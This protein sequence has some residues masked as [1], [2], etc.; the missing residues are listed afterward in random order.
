MTVLR[1]GSATDVG[2]VRAVNEDRSLESETLFAV[3]DGM[4]GHAGGEVAA[5]TA[6]DSLRGGFSKMPS[7]EGLVDAV[8]DANQAVWERGR[9]EPS[10]R[11]MGTTLVAAALVG[12][13]DGDRLAV[14]NVG[15][16][17]AYRLHQGV[18]GQLSTDHS[19]AEALVERGE[20][21]EQEAAVHPHRHIL[22]R[23]LGVDSDVDVDIW[24]LVPQQGDRYLLCS[25]GLSNEVQLE[26]ME[27]VLAGTADPKEAAETL[28]RL[29][30]ESGG[31]D[32]ITALVLDVV[33]G[34]K[35][36]GNG[37][38][39]SAIATAMAAAPGVSRSRNWD[40]VPTRADQAGEDGLVAQPGYH[41]APPPVRRVQRR[42]TFRVLLFVLVLAGLGYGAWAVIRWYVDSS[43]FVGLRHG[44]VTIFQGRRGGF[45]GMDPKVV[46]TSSIT[47]AQVPSYELSNLRAGVEEPSK[48]AAERYVN[49]LHQQLC[50]EQPPP[51]GITCPPPTSGP[52]TTTVP[53]STTTTTTNA[54][55]GEVA[56]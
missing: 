2:R 3:A 51:A 14:A 4:G 29:A 9:S 54:A 20:L 55:V 32:N 5:G 1:S 24:E 15:D 13:D 17:R 45:L 39:E 50:S 49:N 7:V 53:T 42:M 34:E 21:S 6:I 56:G 16:S 36:D 47:Q 12:T 18:L 40:V 23:A 30:N 35:P 28:V 44:E 27:R 25:D 26:E 11:G 22:T 52:T 8:H 38:T 43:Y 41:L 48:K 37:Q 31:N 19:V 10:L 33:V 46:K